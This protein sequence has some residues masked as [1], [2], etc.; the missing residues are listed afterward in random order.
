MHY[1]FEKRGITIKNESE[2]NMRDFS[3]K[4]R[5]VWKACEALW[6]SGLPV[7]AITGEKI[8]WQL[9]ELGFKRGSNSDLYRYK[10]SWLLEKQP[11]MQECVQQQPTDRI[12]RAASALREEIIAELKEEQQTQRTELE[13][14]IDQLQQKQAEAED[15]ILSLQTQ[16]QIRQE[17]VEQ[18]VAD[19][20]A[21]CT[22]EVSL[23][24]TIAIHQEKQ[25][26]LLQQ[27]NSEQKL[28]ET[29]IEQLNTQH[30]QMASDMAQQIDAAKTW[31]EEQRHHWIVVHDALRQENKKLAATQL[32]LQAQLQEKEQQ[33]L[34]LK[35]SLKAIEGQRQGFRQEVIQM[36]QNLKS[37][38]PTLQQQKDYWQ[39]VE[40][41]LQARLLDHTA[42]LAQ[43]QKQHE[44][45]QTHLYQAFADFLLEIKQTKIEQVESI[46]D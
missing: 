46:D 8:A 42:Q 26:M 11:V 29:T 18:L 5:E 10:K 16:L 15:T 20:Q 31:N 41:E 3:R 2:G 30:L 40:A 38:V 36:V 37:H 27:L 9:L 7:E 22:S 25:Q 32:K 33:A 12:S 6:E 1:T 23:K 24:Q 17:E 4:E 43:I 39:S 21:L 19:K 34:S 14:K 35:Q 45:G 28:F 13:S 44:L